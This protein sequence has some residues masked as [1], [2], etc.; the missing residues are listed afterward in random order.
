MKFL[1]A[2]LALLPF[3]IGPAVK[4]PQALKAPV[5]SGVWIAAPQHNTMLRSPKEI[6]R[7]LQILERQGINTLFLCVWADNKTAYQSKVLLNNSNY[8]SLEET[9]M[10]HP[11]LP[12][13]HLFDPVRTLIH[14]AHKKGMKVVFWFEYGFMAQWGKEPTPDQH[15][16]LAAKPHW[17]SRGNNGKTANYNGS[18]YYFNAYHP[19][20]Q[21]FLLDL[22]AESLELYPEVDGIQGDDRLPASPANSGY[23]DY[24][25]SLYRGSFNGQDP[26]SD[27]RDSQWFNWRIGLLNKFAVRMRDLV[28]SKNKDYLMAFSPNP[29]PWCLENLMQDWPSW[30]EQGLVDML[31]VQCYRTNMDSYSAT[32]TNT[33]ETASAAGL[34]KDRF[35]PGIILGIASKRMINNETLDSI[36]H[37]NSVQGYGGQSL[38]YV[39]WLTEDPTLSKTVRKWHHH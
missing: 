25:V 24:T 4:S 6:G 10:F 15:P 1:P 30:I 9:S 2:L 32:V 39:K 34:E 31:N 17:E 7:Q 5:V 18:D 23:D 37:F 12:E 19:E 16:I 35:V 33:F 14:A 21:Q 29:F 11:Y 20:V 13:Q 38:F 36:L 8:K 27:F 28:K 26:P 22:I 3:A